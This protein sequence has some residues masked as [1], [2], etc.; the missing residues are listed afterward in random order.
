M[1]IRF[2]LG[3]L[4]VI[5]LFLFL[6]YSDF[7]YT[8]RVKEAIA[9]LNDKAEKRFHFRPLGFPLCTVMSLL[10]WIPSYYIL[11]CFLL[12]EYRLLLTIVYFG[13]VTVCIYFYNRWRASAR[14]AWQSLPFMLVFTFV[15]GI[16]ILP[17]MAGAHALF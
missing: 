1:I 8:R 12:L 7:Y 2:G 14:I 3:L 9:T 15:T 17:I 5:L 10:F 4:V 16:V 13:V 11:T 6:V